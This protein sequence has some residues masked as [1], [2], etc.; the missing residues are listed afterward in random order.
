MLNDEYK[1]DP[2]MQRNISRKYPRGR[3]QAIDI[4]CSGQLG[5]QRGVRLTLVEEFGAEVA[6]WRN[7]GT[8][9]TWE[10]RD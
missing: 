8:A 1:M 10:S 5:P 6:P 9:Q 4:S 2:L 7:H 3:Y